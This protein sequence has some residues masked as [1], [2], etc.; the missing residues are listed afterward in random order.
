LRNTIKR[1]LESVIPGDL[2]GYVP[3]SFDILGSRSGAV[4][5]IEIPE[6]LNDYETQI[7]EAI[8]AVHGNVKSVLGK[9]S[10]RQGE[11]RLRELRLLAGDPNTEVI[12]KESRCSFKLNPKKTYF[13]TRESTE[14]ERVNNLVQDGEEVLIM[15]SGVAPFPVCIA[16]AHPT[17]KITGVEVNPIAHSYAIENLV[18]NRVQDRVTLLLGDVREVC[19]SLGKTFDRVLMPLPK[20]AYEFLDIAVPMVKSEGALHLYHWA[21]ENNLFNEAINLVKDQASKLGREAEFL[22]G[23]KVSLYSPRVY[24][25]RADFRLG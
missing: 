20:G 7:A 14:R 12:H 9:E 21:P 17:V 5:I 18:L 22:G 13:S 1:Q 11:Y 6:V 15:F 3:R 23:D 2:I 24:K 8:M 16:R 4:A 10:E 25:I 19:P